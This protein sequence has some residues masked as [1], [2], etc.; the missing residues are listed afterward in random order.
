MSKF[1]PAPVALLA[2][3]VLTVLTGCRFENPL[4]SGP[5]K[6]TNSWLL[7]VWETTD[8]KGKVIGRATVT[9][10][11]AGRYWLRVQKPGGG[12]S[13][14]F[15]LEGWISRVGR[16][17]FLTLR[18]IEGPKELPPDSYAFAHYQVLD[19]N[20]VRIRIPELDSPPEATSMQLR[21]E[22]RKRLKDQSLYP[23]SGTNW[24][25]ISEVYWSG[26]DAPQPF[27]PLRFPQTAEE[28]AE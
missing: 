26:D 20:H 22:V 17:S 5:S 16:S 11:S 23:N 10:K 3:A 27:Q 19:Q 2:L 13:Q 9:P 25:R 1:C 18:S 7:G 28:A 15:L 8:D 6:D 24:S 12:P 21:R 14:N 4:T